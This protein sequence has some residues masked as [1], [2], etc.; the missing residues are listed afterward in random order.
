MVYVQKIR[1]QE[2][3]QLSKLIADRLIHIY[4]CW[5]DGHIAYRRREGAVSSR[6]D[7]V[8]RGVAPPPSYSKHSH[9]TRPLDIYERLT[10]RPINLHQPFRVAL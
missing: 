4:R 1:F 7:P 2:A 5:L 6:F 10:K 3:W 9:S 8:I